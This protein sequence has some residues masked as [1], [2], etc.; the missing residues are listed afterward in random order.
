MYIHVLI[1]VN[2]NLQLTLTPAPVSAT[3]V[4]QL[5]RMLR[6]IASKHAPLA[7]QMLQMHYPT[8]LCTL[9][10]GP[11]RSQDTQDG[12][13]NHIDDDAMIVDEHHDSN[14]AVQ[15]ISRPPQQT[16]EIV[17]LIGFVYSFFR[18]V[19]LF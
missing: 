1:F 4:Q 2:F 18:I 8:T 14:Q 6:V 10:V 17:L 16:H 3:S 19:T 15:L 13:D 12:G 5:V 11:S 7:V 9:L